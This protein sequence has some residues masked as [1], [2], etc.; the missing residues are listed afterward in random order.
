[1]A[2]QPA[3]RYRVQVDGGDDDQPD[4]VG[5]DEVVASGVVEHTLQPAVPFADGQP[6]GLVEVGLRLVV[7]PLAVLDNQIAWG[8]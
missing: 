7:L 2:A 8:Q 3:S 4:A 1:M 6:V 5:A